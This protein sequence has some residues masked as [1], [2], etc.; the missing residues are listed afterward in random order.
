MV[1]QTDTAH[2]LRLIAL[3]RPLFGN[4]TQ[5]RGMRAQRFLVDHSQLCNAPAR[6]RHL[7]V[8]GPNFGQMVTLQN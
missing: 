7:G 2:L 6:A 8:Q 1:F 5:N 3:P 4:H